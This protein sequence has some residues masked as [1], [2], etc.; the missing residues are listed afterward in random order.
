MARKRVDALVIG[1]GAAGLAAAREL[2]QAGKSVTIVEARQRIGGRIFTLHDRNWPLPVELGAEFVH[3]EAEQTFAIVRAAGIL[4]DELPDEHYWSRGGTFETIPDFWEKVGRI[5][6]DIARRVRRSSTTDFSFARFVARARIPPELRQLMLNFVEG[7]HAAYTD[8]I[9]ARSLAAGDEEAKDSSGNKQFRIISG[10]DALVHWLR[11][12][13]DPERV[14]LHLNTV[15][16]TVQWK[17]GAVLLPCRSGTGHDLEPFRG[18]TVVVAIPLGVLK[19]QDLRFRPVLEDKGRALEKLETGQVFKI[20]LQFRQR[21]WAD[22]G[23]VRRRLAAKRAEPAPLNFVHAREADVPTWW[24]ALPAQVPLLTGWAGGPKADSLLSDTEATRIER[25]LAALSGVLGVPRGQ[26]EELLDCWATHDWR[27]DPFSR[28][29]YS[30]VGVGGVPAQKALARPVERTVF[31][32]GE[33]TEPD[34]T[35]TVAGAIAS[36]RRAAREVLQVLT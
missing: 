22:D 7:Y 24:T 12:G 6:R 33:A 26:L 2:S 5:R 21:F 32:A 36:G 8:A 13:L 35:A 31:F 28:G 23:F 19:A 9:S 15:A 16:T 3:G 30:Y 34:E 29:A 14:E 1:A 10:T 27:S 11:G 20:V 18:R 4:V 25:S 17:R